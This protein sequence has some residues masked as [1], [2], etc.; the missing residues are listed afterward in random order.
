MTIAPRFIRS[1]RV[2]NLFGDL[3]YQIPGP[4]TDNRSSNRVLLY[5]DNGSGK[6]TILR[7]AYWLLNPESSKQLRDA[8]GQVPFAEFRIDFDNDLVVSL[9]RKA[10]E[11]GREA[12]DGVI[13]LA[14]KEVLRTPIEA[15]EP[16]FLSRYSASKTKGDE[17]VSQIKGLGVGVFFLT[18]DRQMLSNL[19]SEEATE[20]STG[21]SFLDAYANVQKGNQPKKTAE[22]LEKCI[23]RANAWARQEAISS[24]SQ[25]ELDTT[26]IYRDIVGR[27]V[28]SPQER[29]VPDP[30]TE[31]R[32]QTLVEDIRALAERTSEYAPYGLANA[33]NPDDFV[34]VVERTSTGRVGFV[35]EVLRPFI[36]STEAKLTALASVRDAMHAFVDNVNVFLSG[37]HVVFDIKDGIRVLDKRNAIL[38]PALLSS[39]E[40]H[41]LLLF[42]NV[43]LARSRP[44]IFL[45]DEPELSL[46]VKWQQGLLGSLEACVK[47]CQVQFILAT[48]ST[49]ILAEHI[50]EVTHLSA[51][52]RRE[53]R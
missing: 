43:L 36:K 35:D 32:L 11:T 33:L 1:I 30:K 19:F 51:V 27:I 31:G 21:L 48:H 47:G 38:K 2:K 14:G 8:V 10:S 12:F 28:N 4:A 17:F 5:G 16:S 15:G 44:T 37:K 23:S 52:Q 46:N 9:E 53:Q 20:A 25:G 3:D 22:A 34:K 18:D 42:G 45:I 49:D 50:H 29:V 26:G 13:R 7:L 40:K 24:S 41:L 39:G 6:T